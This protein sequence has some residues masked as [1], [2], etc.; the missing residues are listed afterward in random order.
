MEVRHRCFRFCLRAAFPRCPPSHHP[1]T[2]SLRGQVVT[3]HSPRLAP[4]F[5]YPS[6][7]IFCLISS[8]F[9]VFSCASKFRCV[10]IGSRRR[11][12]GD[13]KED[14]EVG[15]RKGGGRGAAAKPQ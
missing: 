11:K 9:Y 2:G 14:K 3:R 13:I 8:D 15:R 4:L 10:D 6:S 12:K 1:P 5:Q 7:S